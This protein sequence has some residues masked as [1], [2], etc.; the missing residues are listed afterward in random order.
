L[1]PDELFELGDANVQES[2]FV[3]DVEEHVHAFDYRILPVADELRLEVVFAA[4]FRLGSG[5]GEKLK[6]DLGFEVSGKGTLWPRH[7][8]TP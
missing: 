5:A 2:G 3:V 1:A 6:N 7:R 8:I 4:K